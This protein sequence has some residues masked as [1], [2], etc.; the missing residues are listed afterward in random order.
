MNLRLADQANATAYA[1]GYNTTH[2]ASSEPYLTSWQD[3]AAQASRI[4]STEQQVL[5]V[6]SWLIGLLAV[7]NVAV[8][9]GGRMAGQVRRVGLLKAMG[10]TPGLVAVVLLAEHLV[11]AL[12]AVV[13]AAPLVVGALT[14][15]PS[16]VAARASVAPTLQAEAA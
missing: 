8:L 7:A 12:A 16:R 3:I 6:G 15:V 10:A 14:V 5:L 13:I 1:T 4:V 11:L 9:A 2:T